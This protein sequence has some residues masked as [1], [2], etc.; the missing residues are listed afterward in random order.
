MLS[1]SLFLRKKKEKNTLEAPG[2][3]PFL[4]NTYIFQQFSNCITLCSITNSLGKY[5]LTSY[6]VPGTV[7]GP[8]DIR[9]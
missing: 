9:M 8:G 4:N 5:L 3:L 2:A 1:R 6:H 7:Q